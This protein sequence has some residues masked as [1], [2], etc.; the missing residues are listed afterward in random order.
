MTTF[1][2]NETDGTSL[3]QIDPNFQGQSANFITSD[4]TI[5]VDARNTG[6]ST[7]LVGTYGDVTYSCM[8]FDALTNPVAITC[9]PSVQKKETTRGYT[10]SVQNDGRVYVDKNGSWGGYFDNIRGSFDPTTTGFILLVEYNQSTGELIGYVNGVEAGRSVDGAPLTG[11]YPGFDTGGAG[12]P[13]QAGDKGVNSAWSNDATIAFPAPNTPS[14]LVATAVNP[15]VIGLTWTDNSSDEVAFSVEQ[16]SPEASG[17]W[18]AVATTAA[19]ATAYTVTGLSG[20]TS[21]RFRL[22]ADG[23]GPSSPY[24]VSNSIT[25]SPPIPVPAA[26]AEVSVDNVGE[27]SVDVTW[28]DTAT[29]EDD[30]LIQVEA[31]SGSGNWVNAT[32]TTQ[33][34][35]PAGT[36]SATV[37]ALAG[38]TDYKV[39][40][41][42]RNLGGTASTSSIQFTTLV[43]TLPTAPTNVVET[44]VTDKNVTVYWE[45]NSTNE[46]GFIVQY[47]TPIGDGNWTNATGAANPTSPNASSFLATGLTPNTAY[48]FRVASTNSAGTSEY[49]VGAG[50]TT[51]VTGTPYTWVFDQPDG[52]SLPSIDS[53]FAVS[54]NTI[55]TSQGALSQNVRNT[56][57]WA[58]ISSPQGS[59]QKSIASVGVGARSTWVDP[60]VCGSNLSTGYS[61]GFDSGLPAF[62]RRGVFVSRG[63]IAVDT[64][65]A[66]YEYSIEFDATTRT[67]T[68]RYNGSV[69]LTWTDN[70]P[71]VGGAPGFLIGS[72]G[73]D[74][75]TTNPGP[76]LS[77][78]DGVT[79]VLSAPDEPVMVRVDTVGS[80]GATV[81]WTNGD[82]ST[83]TFSIERTVVGS[84]VWSSSSGLNNPAGP[85]DTFHIASGL[86]ADT[87]YKFRV[88]AGNS[89][90][91]SD[92][93]ES[94]EI[95][96]ESL[97]LV[98]LMLTMYPF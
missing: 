73:A 2:F 37:T 85:M 57:N 61:F 9:W 51:K 59:V 81:R 60:L 49:A 88:R 16:E 91:S 45:D 86:L 11:G 84:G 43:V 40:V 70:D 66:A 12:G 98:T 94:P 21:Y 95:T 58:A 19:N 68:G 31:P 42:A 64:T 7:W 28:I 89:A 29:N 54:A 80:T 87:T 32:T 15:Y 25:T 22:K 20:S 62:Y 26:P 24:V 67:L 71:I 18:M 36:A 48:R 82:A 97:G 30:Y 78:S 17:N 52:T 77:W 14:N 1:L 3:A 50:V 38:S 41:V 53:R 76:L 39:R 4:G 75:P 35:L 33:N 8:Q 6:F 27:Q 90:G 79:P 63:S 56:T 74:P 69:V 65:T 46:T 47:E 72:I 83:N 93:V 13:T 44:L 55:I 34:P 5:S 23:Y 96:T 10:L 92:W